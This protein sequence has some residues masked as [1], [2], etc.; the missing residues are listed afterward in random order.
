MVGSI[1]GLPKGVADLDY[2]PDSEHFNGHHDGGGV[3]H[4]HGQHL[5]PNLEG[6]VP[7][8]LL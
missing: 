3:Q 1:L 4:G 8:P 6:D 7:H 5:A 2:Q